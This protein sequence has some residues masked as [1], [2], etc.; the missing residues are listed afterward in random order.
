MID[1]KPI[2]NEEEREFL[3][4]VQGWADD[5]HDSIGQVRKG[6]G[7]PYKTHPRRVR[8]RLIVAGVRDLVV[9]GAASTHD[10]L[11][12]VLPENGDYG[13]E[14]LYQ[15]ILG[16][17]VFDRERREELAEGV[18]R[19]TYEV[20]NVYENHMYPLFNRRRRKA[21]EARRLSIISDQGKMV[22]NAD[23]IDNTGDMT[24]FSRG[25][26]AKWKAEKN[27]LLPL[28]KPRAAQWQA[29]YEL[30]LQQEHLDKLS[31]VD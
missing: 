22:K 8:D 2:F 23:L 30:L 13:P 9:L 16:L 10:I 1:L 24:G 14:E 4:A 6:S 20:T 21:M 15:F 11:E 28:I 18:L 26:M 19:V 31:K 7:L 25:F 12:D 29:S 27:E 17:S 3:R 5:G